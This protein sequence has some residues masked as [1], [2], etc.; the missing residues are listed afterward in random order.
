MPDKALIYGTNM[1]NLHLLLKH[2]ALKKKNPTFSNTAC[3]PIRAQ[4]I[5]IHMLIKC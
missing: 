3:K 1:W 5:H 2:L 4:P